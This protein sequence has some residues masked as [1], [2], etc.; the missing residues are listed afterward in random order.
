MVYDGDGNRVKKTVAGVTTTY[1]VD[2]QNPTGYAQV[3]QESMSGSNGTNRELSRAFVYGLE[4][5]SQLRSYLINGT[6]HTQTSYYV[7]DGHGS[8]RALTDP[9]GAVTDTYDNVNRLKTKKPDPSFNAPTVTY[10][11][12]QIG[13]VDGRRSY[14]R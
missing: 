13:G 9:N 10:T 5:I 8:T 6:S 1:L 11:Y 3:V 7:Y 12:S 4:R 14:A 2:T